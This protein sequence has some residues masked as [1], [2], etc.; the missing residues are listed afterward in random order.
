MNPGNPEYTTTAKFIFA[1]GVYVFNEG[2]ADNY[3]EDDAG[4]YVLAY[5]DYSNSS[6]PHYIYSDDTGP[7]DY[8]DYNSMTHY[9]YVN[10]DGT[11][12]YIDYVS[13]THYRF[14]NPGYSV[15]P[16][17]AYIYLPLSDTYLHVAN[18]I[19][20][21]GYYIQ[22]PVSLTYVNVTTTLNAN[23]YYIQ[24][25][26][27]LA[28]VNVQNSI[29]SGNEY[30][31]ISGEYVSIK[32]ANRYNYD[33]VWGFGYVQSNTGTYMRL[34]IENNEDTYSLSGLDYIKDPGPYPD[35][36]QYV[37]QYIPDLKVTWSWS[38]FWGDYVS[39]TAPYADGRAKYKFNGTKFIRDDANGKFI[40]K[41]E[42]PFGYWT[43]TSKLMFDSNMNTADYGWIVFFQSGGTF[44]VNMASFKLK[45]KE[46]LTFEK[47][48]VFLREVW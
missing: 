12:S 46:D 26:V 2:Y 20:S 4:L 43:Y 14:D 45:T 28:Y 15:D 35:V 23:G 27:S 8:F 41:F 39:S 5:I 40:Q 16:G 11:Y 37:R 24:L 48:S 33:P 31:N 9:I 17:G 21:Y 42:T 32:P 18:H 19:A 29:T 7:N 10:D 13:Q 38:V 25:P 3:K 6:V 22:L 1:D 34:F 30:V 36:G 47:F 44:G